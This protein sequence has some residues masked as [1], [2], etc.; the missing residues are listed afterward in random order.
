MRLRKTQG[1]MVVWHSHK[2]LL[3]LVLVL[4]SALSLAG[5]GPGASELELIRE[6]AQKGDPGGELLYGLALIEGRYGLHPDPAKGLPW[7]RRAAEGGNAYAALVLGNA[8]ALGKG[9]HKDPVK[10]VFWW[11][12]AADKEVAEAAYHLGRAFAEGFGVP[13]DPRKAGY[14][15]RQ[16]A[17]AGYPDAQYALGRM[18]HEGV[19]V[20]PDQE[21]AM[22][23]LRR[24]A[25]NG[26]REAVHLLRL[27]ESLVRAVMPLSQEGYEAL[28][29]RAVGN[30]PHAQYEL[31]LRY[32]T[33][34][35]DVN[36]DPRKAL[37]WFRQAAKHGNVLAMHRL[38]RAYRKGELGL[39]VN[40]DKARYWQKRARALARETSR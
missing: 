36:A 1:E 9:T 14:W 33:G 17:D 18:L 37:F 24:A 26:H 3:W 11:R 7:I 12:K 35:L 23:W 13:K 30:D 8:Y 22:A 15:L 28:H 38:A 29:R 5:D 20:E 32:E 16:A 34:A 4:F 21:T 25:A 6:Q 19:V 31:A 27:I 40:P 39:P 10:A 2:L